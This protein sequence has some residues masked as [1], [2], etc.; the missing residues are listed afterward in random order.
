MKLS[1]AVLMLS[2]ALG[3]GYVSAEEMA[4]MPD[5]G[6]VDM[7]TATWG[8]CPEGLPPGCKAMVLQGDPGKADLFTIRAWFPDGYKIP[9]HYHP[10][11]ENLTVISGSFNLGMGDTID[12]AKTQA[13]TPGN[14]AWMG[15]KM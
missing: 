13:I 3:A 1:I 7:K 5:H 10:T 9:S 15:A 6:V 14:F 12:P 11:S 2:V 8:P 4:A